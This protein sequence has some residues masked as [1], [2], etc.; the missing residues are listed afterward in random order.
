MID[1]LIYGFGA[2]VGIALV[3]GVAIVALLFAILR[4]KGLDSRRTGD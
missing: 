4:Y 3:T 1:D 2:C